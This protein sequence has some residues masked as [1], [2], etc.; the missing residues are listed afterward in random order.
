MT[1]AVENNGQRAENGRFANGNTVGFQP[2][3]TGNANGRPKGRSWASRSTAINRAMCST[4][5]WSKN[6]ALKLKLDPDKVSVGDL[7][8]HASKAHILRGQCAF[9]VEDNNRTEG[10][11]GIGEEHGVSITVVFHQAGGGE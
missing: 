8:T 2:G 3:T 11:L 6:A 9:L 5:E 1:E 4:Y 10:K 7:I